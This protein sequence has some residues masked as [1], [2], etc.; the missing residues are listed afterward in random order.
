MSVTLPPP[1]PRRKGCLEP[2]KYVDPYELLHPCRS[3]ILVGI[4]MF[5]AL[6]GLVLLLAG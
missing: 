3:R 1:R 2:M 5:A 4:V 6:A